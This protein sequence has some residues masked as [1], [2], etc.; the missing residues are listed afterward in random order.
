MREEKRG[1]CVAPLNLSHG[2]NW[3]LQD[4]LS[5]EWPQSSK[6]A[7]AFLDDCL[8]LPLAL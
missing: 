4:C 5:A 8:L 1:E 6:E 2:Q 3:S 7:A